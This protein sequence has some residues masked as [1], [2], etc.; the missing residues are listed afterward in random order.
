MATYQAP[1]KGAY[2]VTCAFGKA[3]A[4][5]AG[6]HIGVDLVGESDKHIYPIAAGTV[7]SVNGHGKAYGNH[8]TVRHADG[9]ESLY[10]HLSSVLVKKGQA[11][12]LSTVLGVEG[13]SGNARGK[14]L[15]LEVH[16]GGYRY[17]AK[18]SSP[19]K[20]AWL[21]NPLE[22]FEEVSNVEKTLVPQW[23]K[24]ACRMVCETRG[25]TNPDDWLKKVE[26]GETPTWGEIFAVLAKCL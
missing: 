11:V 13:A 8:V 22:L 9:K 26:T 20:C 24:D 25:F 18:G 16:M 14:H 4:W 17:P 5:Q 23:Q 6:W 2:K 15:H 10:A 3:G 12:T 19:A 7:S 1:Y 21:V